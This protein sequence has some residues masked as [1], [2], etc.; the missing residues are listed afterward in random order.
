M[1]NT[2]PIVW[3]KAARRDFEDFP[4]K[5]R[6]R[7]LDALTVVAEGAMPAIANIPVQVAQV[8]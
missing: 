2:R 8:R 5:A 7:L 4:D 1:R 6:D 3:L